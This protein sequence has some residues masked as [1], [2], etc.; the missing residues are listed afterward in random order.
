MQGAGVSTGEVCLVDPVSV[1]SWCGSSWSVE[2]GGSRTA[3][4]DPQ[5][6]ERLLPIVGLYILDKHIDGVQLE[7]FQS[8]TAPSLLQPL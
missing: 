6:A 8:L 3:H 5:K 4:A 7:G 1:S 2:A